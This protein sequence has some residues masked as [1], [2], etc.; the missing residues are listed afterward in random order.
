MGGLPKRATSLRLVVAETLWARNCLVHV[1]NCALGPYPYLIAKRAEATEVV[2][3]DWAFNGYAPGHSSGFRYGPRILDNKAPLTHRN[4][5]RRVVQIKRSSVVE[6]G[7]EPLVDASVELDEVPAGSKRKPV[8]VD[9]G[10]PSWQPSLLGLCRY[11]PGVNGNDLRG[12]TRSASRYSLKALDGL[13][14]LAPAGPW[15]VCS[16]A[17]CQSQ[18]TSAQHG[19]QELR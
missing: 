13:S 7:M 10:R 17:K 5:E 12:L 14:E 15:L 8:Q 2:A 6:K 4:F 18:R 11:L 9:G 3:P 19:M 16:R 1:S